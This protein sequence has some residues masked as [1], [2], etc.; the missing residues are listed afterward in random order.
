MAPEDSSKPLLRGLTTGFGSRWAVGGGSGEGRLIQTAGTLL[1]SRLAPF[2]APPRGE[3]GNAPGLL[4]GLRPVRRRLSHGR[5][6]AQEGRSQSGFPAG[7]L[8]AGVAVRRRVSQAPRF[9][10]EDRLLGRLSGGGGG[11]VYPEGRFRG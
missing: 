9:R 11:G 1:P 5:R 3:Q 8:P 2:S 10:P 6:Q 4:R 7:V